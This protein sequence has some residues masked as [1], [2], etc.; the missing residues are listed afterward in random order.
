MRDIP[1]GNGNLLAA[2]DEG[3]ILREFY[4]PHVG[5]ENHTRG[6]P[7]RMGIWLDGTINWIPD[8]WNVINDYLDHS[9]VTNV[10]LTHERLG[11][12]IQSNDLVDYHENIYLKKITLENLSDER[13]EGRFFLGQ[14]FHIYGTDIGDTAA[15]K[16]ETNGL[17]HY[18]GERYFLIGLYANKKY[19]IDLYS[20][21]AKKSGQY[22]G[23]WKDA[24]D[25]VLEQNPIAQGSVDSILG[26]PFQIEGKGKETFY[27][28]ISAGKH[29]EE[30][31][32]LDALV[33]LKTPNEIFRRTFNYWKLWIE[34]ENL[35]SRLLPEKIFRLYQRSLLICRTQINNC[36]SIIASNDSDAVDFNRDT[37]SYMWPRDGSFVAYAFDLAGYDITRYFF[38]FCSSILTKEG[39]FLHKY[40]PT[41]SL[42]SSWHPWIKNKKIQLPIQ[43]DETAL[44]VWALWNHYKRFKDIEFVMPL[45][46]SLVKKAADFMMEYRDMKTGLP[47]QSYD[48]WEERQGVFTYTASTVYGGLMAASYFAD[49]FGETANAEEYRQGAAY[50]KQ[51]MD[52]YLYLEKEKRFAR[53][54]RFSKEGSWEVDPAIDSS[55][56]AI[57]YFG[58][59]APSDPR[60]Q[61]TMD[62]IYKS[63]WNQNGGGIARYENDSYYRDE[64]NRGKGPGNSWFITTLWI[65]QYRIAASQTKK[66]LDGALEILEWVADHALPS[67]VLAE[68]LDPLTHRP[69]SVSP[70]TWSHGNFI[71]AVQEY[72][73]KLKTYD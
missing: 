31:A 23:T 22:E 44:V 20:T 48:L 35:D 56:Y 71:A 15:F 46:Q 64:E 68:Q 59:Y 2:F 34:K 12:Q 33:R 61:S 8:G 19:G 13:K 26:I 6:E 51:G 47:L 37:Y 73:N 24:E 38:Q 21:G 43:E 10:I 18:K 14:D 57:F 32:A 53:S 29:W 62:Q 67:G 3:S 17:L 42:A 28:W 36:G 30:V 65:A 27:Y 50:L 1:V 66:E 4:F 16:P 9:L 49:A 72:L 25:G 63:L 7:F 60:V 58:V 40:T 5:E 69:I 52:R 70:L 55:L 39:Y 11:L 54:V 45:Y 41:G